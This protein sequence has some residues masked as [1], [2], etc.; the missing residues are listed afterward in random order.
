MIGE[1]SKEGYA[2]CHSNG[3]YGR[4]RTHYGLLFRHDKFKRNKLQEQAP[5]PNSDVPSAAIPHNPDPPV[6]EP[7][8]NMEYNFNSEQSYMADVPRNEA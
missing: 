3:L 4:K 8:V 1:W 6:P 5:C 2:I 7:D